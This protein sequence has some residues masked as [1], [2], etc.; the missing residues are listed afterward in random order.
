MPA[1]AFAAVEARA[2]SAPPPAAAGVAA[3]VRS[4]S[5]ALARSLVGTVVPVAAGSAFLRSE[6]GLGI[7]VI[8]SGLVFGPVPGYTYGDCARRGWTGA[9]LRTG[10]FVAD[11]IVLLEVAR[12]GL[13][14]S[15]QV[16]DAAA[17][18][19]IGGGG[20]IAIST[21]YD[22]AV[23]RRH[24]RERNATR[25]GGDPVRMGLAPARMPTGAPALALV[26]RF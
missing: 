13:M 21:A 8:S 22:L 9:A 1:L 12:H 7:L 19:V 5:G 6:A 18:T 20:A 26:A 23:L 4:E 17:G 15:S 2:Q 24:V 16:D 11:L 14:E 10:I 25:A 3:E